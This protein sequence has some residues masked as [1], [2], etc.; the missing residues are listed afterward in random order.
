MELYV[1]ISNDGKPSTVFIKSS[2]WYLSGFWIRLS[3]TKK[4]YLKIFGKNLTCFLFL[5]HLFWDSPFW[6]VTDEFASHL[7]TQNF[8]KLWSCGLL[9]RP[10][11][12]YSMVRERR[13][14]ELTGFVEASLRPDQTSTVQIFY[15]N[16][17]RL[18]AVHVFWKKAP[19]EMFDRVLKLGIKT[20]CLF[21]KI[22]VI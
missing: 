12:P 5:K 9:I 14:F 21:Y 4:I 19:F 2:L 16:S 18:I 10:K 6:L 3:T 13:G 8:C 1:K 7:F 22:V 15:E 11:G 17:S 20:I